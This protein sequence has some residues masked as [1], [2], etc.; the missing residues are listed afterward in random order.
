[1][2]YTSLGFNFIA[3][4]ARI[5]IKKPGDK[6][7]VLLTVAANTGYKDKASQERVEKA[8]FVQ[9]QVWNPAIVENIDK[10]LKVG[11]TVHL[12]GRVETS[13]KEDGGETTYY[14]NFVV[15][16]FPGIIKWPKED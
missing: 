9:V 16:E 3:N 15:T 2:S 14:T 13:Q 11:C 10:V 1:M 7:M 4:V 5:E 12:Q 8:H 6:K